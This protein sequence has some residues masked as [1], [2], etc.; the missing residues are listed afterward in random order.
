MDRVK[1][2]RAR[3]D[4]ALQPSRLDIIDESDQHI[5]HSG[6]GG[7]GHFR[8]RIVSEKFN[9]QSMILRH[10]MVYEALADLMPNEIHALSIDARSA[11]EA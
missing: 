2:I 3:L 11:H 5:G 1:A 4:A 7:A 8:L 9:Y 6:H 10:R